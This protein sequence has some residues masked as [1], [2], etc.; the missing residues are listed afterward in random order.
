MSQHEVILLDS[1]LSTMRPPGQR[2]KET[3]G[4]TGPH[5]TNYWW[6][7]GLFEPDLVARDAAESLEQGIG[8][9]KQSSTLWPGSPSGQALGSARKESLT[10]QKK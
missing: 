1:P 9:E 7:L 2:H 3:I 4:I 6:K 8:S 5:N 10:E